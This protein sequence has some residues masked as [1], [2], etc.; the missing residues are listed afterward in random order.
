M[1]GRVGA[2]RKDRSNL[3]PKWHTNKDVDQHQKETRERGKEEKAHVSP[4]LSKILNCSQRSAMPMHDMSAWLK[5]ALHGMA[6]GIDMVKYFV[7]RQRRSNSTMGWDH[8]NQ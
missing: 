6:C 7:F 1:S 4:R 8:E 5:C 2:K 3:S